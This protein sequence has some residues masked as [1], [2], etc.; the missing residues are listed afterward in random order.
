MKLWLIVLAALIGYGLFLWLTRNYFGGASTVPADLSWGYLTVHYYGIAIAL[1]IF[2]SYLIGLWL[3]PEHSHLFDMLAI[4]LLLGGI[5]GARLGFVLTQSSYYSAHWKE[6]LA[7]NRGGLS[8]HGAIIGGIIVLLLYSAWRKIPFLKMA[9]IIAPLLALGQMIGRFGNFF[10]QEALGAPTNWPWK[11]FVSLPNRPAGYADFSFFHPLFL[12]ESIGSLIIF[13]ILVLIAG[14]QP[15]S[16]LVV[17]WYLV[18]YSMLRFALEII[19]L[20]TIYLGP[21]TEAQWVS[22]LLALLGA[23]FIIIRRKTAVS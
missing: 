20:D 14:R 1:G 6:I 12:Y 18:L 7:F 4:P 5:I 11:M 22:I 2:I 19:R 15:P 8:L 16:G 3:W 13:I 10:N 21:L 23:G 17:G 9:D